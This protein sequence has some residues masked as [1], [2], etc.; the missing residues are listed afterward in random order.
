MN[1]VAVVALATA[2]NVFAADPQPARPLPPECDRACLYGLVDQY[3]DGLAHRDP[4]RVP[5]SSHPRYTEN[6]VEMAPGDGMWGTVTGLGSYQLKF[7]DIHTGQVGFFGVLEEP[8]ARSGFALR[9]KVEDRRVSEA[10]AVVVRIADFP[11]LTGGTNP[12]AKA[13]FEDKPILQKNL[14]SGEGRAR[15]RLI[16]IADGYFD[17]LQLNDGALFTQFDPQCD[18]IE[19][20]IRTTNNPAKPLG[21][22]SALGCEQQFKLGAY[23]YDDQ[24]RARRF[25]LVDEERGLVLGLAFI[26]HSGRLGRFTLTDGRTLDSPIRRPHS[27]CLMEVFKI[28]D[29][30]IRQIEAVFITVPYKMPSPWVE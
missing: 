13:T 14:A 11:P 24:L 1:L 7:A 20:G 5:W 17:T 29:G 4:A 6:N 19:N 26:D 21:E 18:R 9:L 10:E 22:L 27:F 23:R 25:P 30:R 28:V 2:Q 3:L 8:D 12:F 16:S 15:E